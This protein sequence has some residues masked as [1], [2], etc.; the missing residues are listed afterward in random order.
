MLLADPAIG[1]IQDVEGEVYR[2][3]TYAGHAC[4]RKAISQKEFHPAI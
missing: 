4:L 2:T 1:E 3:E